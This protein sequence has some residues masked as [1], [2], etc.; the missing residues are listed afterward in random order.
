MQRRAGFPDRVRR[1][2]SMSGDLAKVVKLRYD[3][4]VAQ[5]AVFGTPA[6]METM[7]R[8]RFKLPDATRA[9]ITYELWAPDD[10]EAEPVFVPATAVWNPALAKPSEFKLV[11]ENRLPV[12]APRALDS[13]PEAMRKGHVA[14]N[15]APETVSKVGKNTDNQLLPSLHKTVHD[16]ARPL[17]LRCSTLSEPAPLRVTLALVR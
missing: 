9:A 16:A 15:K 1:A 3:G 6:D 14:A 13:A 12:G 11:C 7:V 17:L 10:D 8:Q 4:G 5:F 2:A